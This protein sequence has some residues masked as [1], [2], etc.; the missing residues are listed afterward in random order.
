MRYRLQK[1]LSAIIVFLFFSHQLSAQS[2]CLL[3]EDPVVLNTPTIVGN[4]TAASCTQ[5]ALQTA[6]DSGGEIQCNC[7]A[8]LVT[9]VLNAPLLVSQNTILDGGQIVL[10][11]DLTFRIIDKAKFVDFT[12]QNLTLRNGKAPGPAGHFSNECGGAILSRGCRYFKSN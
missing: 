12:L 5:V 7:G 11:G 3:T 1:G 2:D 9:I 10:D 6:L 8:G 4:G